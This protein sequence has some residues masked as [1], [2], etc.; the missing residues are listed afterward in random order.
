MYPRVLLGLLSFTIFHLRA[1]AQSVAEPP[2]ALY[3][4]AVYEGLEGNFLFGVP[5]PA[6]QLKGTTSTNLYFK[7][8]VTAI[9][10]HVL[11]VLNAKCQLTLLE[12]FNEDGWVAHPET[13]KQA[14]FIFYNLSATETLVSVRL[15]HLAV[16]GQVL[17]RLAGTISAATSKG[18]IQMMSGETE[19][20][21]GRK[22]TLGESTAIVESIQ[23]NTTGQQT[24]VIRPDVKG[25]V[26]LKASWK[27]QNVATSQEANI[28]G[29]IAASLSEPANAP[30][31]EQARL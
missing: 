29:C 2:Q 12:I 10:P 9:M 27:S 19:L 5:D 11:D 1:A 24:V 30:V 28:K 31:V 13:M 18:T 26:W 15:P 8:K 17:A 3:G 22:I 6:N 20:K 4:R 14:R 23:S 21:Q 25:G 16:K 7:F